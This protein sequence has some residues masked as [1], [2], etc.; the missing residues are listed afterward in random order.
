[1]A[2]KKNSSARAITPSVEQAGP[3]AQQQKFNKSGRAV[4]Q[5]WPYGKKRRENRK[6]DSEKG[7]EI[8]ATS[9][10]KG[11]ARDAGRR[12]RRYSRQSHQNDADIQSADAADCG[13]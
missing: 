9:R 1:M 10:W 4:H 7:V 6:R 13:A 8:G 12:C 5:D 2:E 11:H 3:A